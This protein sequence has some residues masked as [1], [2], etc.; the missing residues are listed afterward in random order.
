MPALSKMVTTLK[1]PAASG[2]L[3]KPAAVGAINKS[4]EEMKLATKKKTGDDDGGDSDEFPGDAGEDIHRD[5][6]KSVKY[7]RMRDSL[8]DYVVDLIEHQRRQRLGHG[9][10]YLKGEHQS[11]Q[12]TA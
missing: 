9:K 12:L 7:R 2:C 10:R 11:C 5:K 4:I 3:K 1:K 8:P 6:G